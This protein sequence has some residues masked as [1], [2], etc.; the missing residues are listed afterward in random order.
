MQRCPNCD[1]AIETAN[2]NMA[3]GMA[4][5]GACGSLSRLGDLS[6]SSRSTTELLADVP[7]GCSMRTVGNRIVAVASMRSL[8]AFFAAGAF[9]LFW[10]GITGLFV[11]LAAAGLYANLIGPLPDW[12]PAPGAEDGQPQ[13]NDEPMGLGMALFLC[14]FLTPF[15]LVGITMATVSVL[16]LLGRIKVVIERE[17]AYVASGVGWFS[18]KRRFNPRQVRSVLIVRSRSNSEETVRDTIEIMTD[19]STKLGRMLP[20]FRLQWMRA[21]LH[22]LLVPVEQERGKEERAYLSWL[23]KA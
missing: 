13:V 6:L 23:D 4:L 9:A 7:R 17:T 3:E 8:P 10:N 11:L 2:I 21:A 16:S 18:W 19:H 15:V 22:E 14:V 12:F 1:A 20:D 5:C